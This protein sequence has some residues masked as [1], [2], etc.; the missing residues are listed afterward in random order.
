MIVYYSL[1]FFTLFNDCTSSMMMVDLYTKTRTCS[2]CY[3]Y[4]YY[5][6]YFNMHTS[7][8]H[9]TMLCPTKLKNSSTL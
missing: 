7:I 6:Y 5:Y 1:H 8:P 2:Y 9:I 4:Y 3:Y